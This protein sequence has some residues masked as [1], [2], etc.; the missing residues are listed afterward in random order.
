MKVQ[1]IKIN[2]AGIKKDVNMPVLITRFYSL[3]IF[4]CN[5]SSH[6]RDKSWVN[7]T[8]VQDIRFDI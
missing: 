6:F 4:C 1:Y 3:T 5:V 7:T 8:N 2:C